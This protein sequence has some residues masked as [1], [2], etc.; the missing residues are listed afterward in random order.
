VEEGFVMRVFSNG[1][2]V[3]VPRFGIEGLIRLRDLAGEGDKE[4]ESDFD[5]EEYILKVQKDGRTL[6]VELFEKVV[7]K[8]TDEKEEST[9]K[10][11]IKMALV[12]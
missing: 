10:R 2:V 4:P 11:K 1:F 5:A 6:T 8:I 7:V 3:F 9:G 12:M